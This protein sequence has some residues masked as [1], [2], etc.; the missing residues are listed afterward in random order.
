MKVTNTIININSDNPERLQKFYSEVVQL[1]PMPNMGPG[2][3]DIGS[4]AILAVDGHSELHGATK[5]PPRVLLD[6]VVEDLASEQK[7]LEGA[8]VKFIRSAGKEEWG[9]IISTFTDPD[10]NYCQIMQYSG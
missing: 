3:F 8:G 4:G 2:M 5:E 1:P 10:G 7:R 9:G 6:L